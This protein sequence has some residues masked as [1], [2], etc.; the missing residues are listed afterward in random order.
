MRLDDF[1]YTLPQEL[2]AQFP[3]A[4]RGA[5][6]LLHLD[7]RTGALSD[8]K[9]HDIVGLVAPGDV[10][11]ANDTRV[12]KARLAGRKKTGGRVE[13]MVERVRSGGEVLAQIGANHP[14]RV[15]SILN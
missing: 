8:R 13:V 2:I 10:V 7:G 15:G 14:T 4:Q 1:D 12:I 5:S 9:F 3:P 11:V 6:R